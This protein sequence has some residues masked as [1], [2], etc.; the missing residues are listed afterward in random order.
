MTVKMFA[1]SNLPIFRASDGTRYD[2]SST[3]TITVASEHVAEALKAGFEIMT[4]TGTTAQRPTVV[5]TGYRY[6][7]TTLGRTIRYDGS[8]WIVEPDS[9]LLLDED[10]LGPVAAFVTSA[11]TLSPWMSKI[12]GA[13]PPTAGVI[14]GA[15]GLAGGWCALAQTADSQKQ[16]AVLYFGDNL[17]FSLE[18]QPVIEFRAKV[19]VLPTS[20]TKLF[21]GFGSAWADGPDAMTYSAWFALNGSGAVLCET[22]DAVT[23]NSV[24]SG[25]TV[26]NTEIHTYRIDFADLTSIKFY[27]DG[28]RVASG[29][30]FAFTATGANALVQPFFNPYKATGT[31]VGSVQIDNVRVWSNRS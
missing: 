24:A 21:M 12:V 22:D 31:S 6:F 27:I 17:A 25:V 13:A 20:G 15:S 16:D 26:L 4:V 29:T 1:P 8:A 3:G 2:V 28:V 18:E 23:D 5:P 30:T 9:N 11:G 7:D 10:F 19:S 14:A